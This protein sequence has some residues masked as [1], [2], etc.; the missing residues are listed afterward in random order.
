MVPL[1]HIIYVCLFAMGALFI[2]TTQAFPRPLSAHDIGPAVFPMWLAIVMMTL[3]VVDTLISWGRARKV[4]LGNVGLA[5]L[6]ALG[7]GSTVWASSRFGFFYVLP[8]ALYI[9]LWAIG[10][11]RLVVNGIF[12]LVMPVVLW[13]I[14][15]Q[16][17]S[18]PLAR[19]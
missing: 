19:L 5:V 15:D 7:M 17:L 6:F 16:L 3:I 2:W 10:S 1:V 18:I 14:F 12:S 13:A 11:R 8:V 4:P 9:G